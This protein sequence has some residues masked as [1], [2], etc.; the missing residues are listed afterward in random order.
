VWIGLNKMGDDTNFKWIDRNTAVFRDWSENQPSGIGKC[1]YQM[2][3]PKASM[4]QIIA[5]YYFEYNYFGGW[6]GVQRPRIH[7][8]EIAYVPFHL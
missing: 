2:T 4:S 5:A 8:F 3:H 7:I 6:V 1:A